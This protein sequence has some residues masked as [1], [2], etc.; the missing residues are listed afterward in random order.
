MSR[1]S[2]MHTK[3]KYKVYT[4]FSLEDLIDDLDFVDIVKDGDAEAWKGFL[5]LNQDNRDTI[6]AARK[7]I[8]PFI[9]DDKLSETEK[10]KIWTNIQEVMNKKRRIIH[11]YHISAVAACLAVIIA[12][13]VIL[14]NNNA[15]VDGSN[16]E[17]A[18]MVENIDMSTN[19][20][21]LNLANGEVVEVEEDRADIKVETNEVRVNEKFVRVDSSLTSVKQD[22]TSMNEV[23]VPYGKRVTMQLSD[24]T[25]VWLN[26][27]TKFA[28]PNEFTTKQRLVFLDGEGYFEVAKS[29]SKPFIVSSQQMNIEVLGTKFNVS[30]YNSDGFAEA[31]LIEGSVDV[32]R[33]G[34]EG[35]VHKMR[36]SPFER[37]SIAEQAEEIKLVS[38][39]DAMVYVAWIDGWYGFSNESVEVVL[40]KLKRFYNVDFEYEPSVVEK[41]LPISGKLDLGESISDVMYALSQVS[42]IDYDIEN[43]VIRIN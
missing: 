41:A 13:A 26:A 15:V 16:I 38:E 43:K 42:E 17:Y 29:E 2:N 11:V 12:T 3:R 30:T 14:M 7:I 6:L 22:K 24:G 20:L 34:G 1:I 39:Q 8:T 36:M 40:R 9:A 23:I 31:V 19:N 4:G 27:G 33:N 35:D 25:K 5:D 21:T 18:F 28:F 37:A 32:W 10:S